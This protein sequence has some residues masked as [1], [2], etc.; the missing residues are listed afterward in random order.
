MECPTDRP[1]KPITKEFFAIKNERRSKKRK[2]STGIPFINATSECDNTARFNEVFSTK[3]SMICCI[4]YFEFDY[5]K[6]SLFALPPTHLHTHD[7]TSHITPNMHFA[8]L[9]DRNKWQV[10][11]IQVG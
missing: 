10:I 5:S 3:H 6:T 7:P 8:N 9:T 11:V 1:T 4:A 2:R